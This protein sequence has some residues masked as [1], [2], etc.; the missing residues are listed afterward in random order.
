M[1]NVFRVRPSPGLAI[2]ALTILGLFGCKSTTS[3]TDLG[4]AAKLD[5]RV[6]C[7]RPP[8]GT[9]DA[10]FDPPT[11]KVRKKLQ[12][13]VWV[14]EGEGTLDIQFANNPFPAP[15]VCEGRF[16]VALKPPAADKPSGLYPY[17]ATVTVAGQTTAADPNVE[18]VD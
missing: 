2:V 6:V 4:C 1:P 11:I 16:C 14:L 13:V 12:I 18:V 15:P 7:V 10:N 5:V 3:M 17:T 9:S 8:G